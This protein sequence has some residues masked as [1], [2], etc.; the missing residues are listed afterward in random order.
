MVL[1]RVRTLSIS[2]LK[3]FSKRAHRNIFYRTVR[4]L[5]FL[6]G[7]NKPC[8]LA[9]NKPQ[10]KEGA[11]WGAE[12]HSKCLRGNLHDKCPLFFTNMCFDFRDVHQ[13][14]CT[15]WNTWI[16]STLCN[17]H[18]LKKKHKKTKLSLP[19]TKLSG[20]M[21]WAR[22]LQA[23]AATCTRQNL[24]EHYQPMLKRHMQFGV[25]LLKKY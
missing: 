12:S 18:N 16:S 13:P 14:C 2:W 7:A 3:F 8:C 9:K 23:L 21:L 5:Y 6:E 24:L 11:E 19:P 15:T 22:G 10:I 25:N 1:F 4:W 17:I 20:E